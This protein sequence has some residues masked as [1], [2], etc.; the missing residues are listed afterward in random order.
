MIVMLVALARGCQLLCKACLLLVALDKHWGCLPEMEQARPI[1]KRRCMS[2][3]SGFGG[4][5]AVIISG[6][7]AMPHIG[8]VPGCNSRISGSMG[9]I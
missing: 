1:Q 4:A 5:S 3:S 8:Q 7:S 2:I 9:Q 6:S